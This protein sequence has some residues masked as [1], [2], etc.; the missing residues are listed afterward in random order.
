[1]QLNLGQQGG[2]I[3]PQPFNSHA[4]EEQ[5]SPR[6]HLGTALERESLLAAIHQVETREES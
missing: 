6:S 2:E 4:R 5:Y 1:M 3:Y